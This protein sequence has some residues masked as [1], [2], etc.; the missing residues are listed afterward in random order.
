MQ[1]INFKASDLLIHAQTNITPHNIC[2]LKPAYSEDM[3]LTWHVE[4]FKPS[5]LL[6]VLEIH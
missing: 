1:Y 3:L 2:E 5:S 6:Q 4:C